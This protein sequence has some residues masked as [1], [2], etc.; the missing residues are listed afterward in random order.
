MSI[1][2]II[3]GNITELGPRFNLIGLVPS[4][5]LFFFILAHFLLWSE[6]PTIYPDWM[7]LTQRIDSISIQDGI[8]LV[9]SIFLFSLILQPLQLPLVRI[10]E[11]YW[12]N[13]K[14]A[15][16]L[17]K[18]GKSSEMARL[19]EL[20]LKPF[21]AEIHRRKTERFPP[22][23]ERILPTALGNILRAAED[24]VFV[25]YKLEAVA[26]WPLLYPILSEKS[27]EIVDSQR[28]Q[29]DV[30]IRIFAVFIMCSIFSFVFYIAILYRVL[31]TDNIY[32][33]LIESS[34]SMG[35]SSFLVSVTAFVLTIVTYSA[36]LII[37]VTMVFLAWLTYKSA[38]S[39]ATEYGKGINSAFDMNRFELLKALHFPL[40]KNLEKEKINNY[41]L[42]QF[43]VVNLPY[44][45]EYL[46]D[47]S[48]T[49]EKKQ[50]APFP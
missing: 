23:P 26:V 25:K 31:Q 32:F 33:Y 22:L 6:E 37:P 4:S 38:L 36:W 27:K 43:L 44:D 11:G 5:F 29:L 19:K 15:L 14:I 47:G 17:S 20:E 9:I 40:P 24:H 45:V 8:L 28:N 1:A 18:V 7:A 12:G 42:S 34:T 21:D 16:I 46:H 48:A 3:S 2:S 13:S 30:T 39:A 41:K 35:I 49:E 10:I 50:G